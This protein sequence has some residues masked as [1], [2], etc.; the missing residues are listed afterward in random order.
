[1]RSIFKKDK[2]IE[3]MLI[4]A[5]AIISRVLFLG[6]YPV[7][8]HADEVYAGYEAYAMLKYGTDSWGIYKPCVSDYMGKRNECVGVLFNDSVYC[9]WWFE[10]NNNKNP[11][12]Y[13]RDYYSICILAVS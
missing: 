10:Y 4:F 6:A 13:Y 3:Y 9:N 7:G 8:V 2:T 12:G 11:T 5:I 1:M